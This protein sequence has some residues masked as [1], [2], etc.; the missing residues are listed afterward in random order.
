MNKEDLAAKLQGRQIGDEI[1]K[2]EIQLARQAGLVVVFGASDDLMELEGAIRDEASIYNGGGVLLT[3]RG[4]YTPDCENDC[5]PH[6]IRKQK[7]LKEIRAIWDEDGFS[8]QYDT[9][10]PH[11]TFEVFEGSEMYC[12]GIIFSVADLSREALKGGE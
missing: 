7:T 5:C 9:E 4:V 8:W 12:K 3:E 2:E 1:S 10:I 6:E 11:A